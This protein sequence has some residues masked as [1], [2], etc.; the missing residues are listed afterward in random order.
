MNFQFIMPKT[1][2]CI[3]HGVFVMYVFTLSLCLFRCIHVDCL[4]KACF[5][6][7]GLSIQGMYFPPNRYYNY[8]GIHLSHSGVKRLLDAING[9]VKIV[10]NYDL[11]VFSN[12][13]K[14]NKNGSRDK[15]TGYSRGFHGP[16]STGRPYQPYAAPTGGDGRRSKYRNSRKQCY[17]CNMVGHILAECWNLK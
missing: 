3:L 4:Y 10:V 17:G 8:D 13:K 2:L 1:N 15:P 14:Q 6:K 5:S 7:Y 12:T 16:Q 11:C 9:S